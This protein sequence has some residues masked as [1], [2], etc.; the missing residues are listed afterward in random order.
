MTNSFEA[1]MQDM[2]PEQWHRMCANTFQKMAESEKDLVT[3]QR[4]LDMG[5]LHLGQAM[6]LKKERE[7][8]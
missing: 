7:R 1:A 8:T 2:D 3:K 5:L 6:R 4:F